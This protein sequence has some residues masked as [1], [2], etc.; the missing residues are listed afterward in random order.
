M[1]QNES[2]VDVLIVGAG[3]VGLITAYQLARFGGGVSVRIVEKSPRPV[4]DA[5]GRAITL[6]PRTS[7]M[8]DQLDL[9]DELL[10]EAFACRETAAYNSRG[11]EVNGRGW[12]FMNQMKDTAF[13]F[14][15]VLRQKYQEEIYRKALKRH[16]I[17]VE[18]PVELVGVDIDNA[19]SSSC[20][21]ITATVQDAEKR[22]LGTIKCK[23]LIG[24]DGGRSSVRRLLSIPF[25][26]TTS[27][28]KW[29]RVDGYVRTDLPKPRTYCSIESLT[30]GNVLWV[31]LDRG[32]TR[33]GYAFTDD[34][35][36]AYA[37]FDE[38][39]AITEAIAAVKP[40]S[41]EF[42]QVEWWT[43]YTVG[44]RVA[45]NFSVN[46]RVFLVGDACHTHSSGAAQGLN[47]GIH[48]TVNL[49]WKL[50]MVLRGLALPMLLDTYEMERR[51]NVL[52][53]IRYDADISRLMTN[54]LP[55]TWQGEP[56]AD[57]NEVLGQI[58]EEAGTFSSGLSI[59]Y[60][61]T[62]D[63]PLVSSTQ[64][65]GQL[66]PGMRAP[67]IPLLKPGTF[68]RTRLI[69]ETPNV[70][71]FYVVFFVA[72]GLQGLP[73]ASLQTIKQ[74]KLLNEYII[75]RSITNLTILPTKVPSVYGSLGR[76]Y[77]DI[78]TQ[79]GYQRYG[80]NLDRGGIVVIRPDGWIFALISVDT[81]VTRELESLFRG[82]LYDPLRE[83]T[84]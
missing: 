9:A 33:I 84:Q 71:S 18:A 73:M 49:S 44:Q 23:R 22:V 50:S 77:F 56:T 58:M 68:E 51:P 69:R 41:L 52:K 75:N 80:V 59:A 70:G 38:Q 64:S 83:C 3:P 7:E 5:Y 35:A 32:A 81:D 1:A 48:D 27:E 17:E 79:T 45:R 67:D 74:S 6:F 66:K 10:Q 24:A 60:E 4:Q 43:I 40:F 19:A 42:E 39:A 8:L 12:S 31:G 53:L 25:E 26:G 72:G 11:E 63:N 2:L 14:P 82:I 13:D 78:E 55:E 46:N 65:S 36:N 20:H 61:P 21:S 57:V 76:A 30:H 15:L 54:R 37:E 62:I 34:R 47:T 29:V 16:G 28:D